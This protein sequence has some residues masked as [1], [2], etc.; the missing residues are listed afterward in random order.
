[1]NQVIAW[2]W[3]NF[4]VCQFDQPW[5][6]RLNISECAC[7][8]VSGRDDEHLY[9]WTENRNWLSPTCLGLSRPTDS[10][11]WTER[12]RRLNVLFLSLCLF[13][14]GHWSSPALNLEPPAWLLWFSGL[15][16]QTGTTP[17]LQ[18]NDTSSVVLHS[19]YNYT[20]APGSPACRWHI[21]RILF[22]L[23]VFRR[24]RIQ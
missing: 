4:F 15:W 12:Q 2:M 22:P 21:V 3:W 5:L 6:P 17:E 13:D 18:W 1:M 11:S 16:A 9:G 24:T 23:S 10:P 8:G 19:V 20:Q 7:D 14:L